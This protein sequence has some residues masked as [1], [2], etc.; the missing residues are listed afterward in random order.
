M[1]D[2]PQTDRFEKTY[3]DCS[4]S[5]VDDVFEFA[6]QLERENADLHHLNAE[7]EKRLTT[8]EWDDYNS[9]KH[10][11]REN[12]ELKHSG[13]LLQENYILLLRD[14]GEYRVENAALR[15]KLEKSN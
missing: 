14:L 5:H 11:Q 3:F 10:L 12:A 15:A 7:L 2:T 1:S 4:T 9:I 13:S 8:D 6:R